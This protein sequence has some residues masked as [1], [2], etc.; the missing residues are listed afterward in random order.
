[1]S[2]KPLF[3]ATALIALFV[4]G[5]VFWYVQKQEVAVNQPVVTDSVGEAPAQVEPEKYPQHIE[6]IPGNTDEVWYNI[7][8]L[9]IRMKLNKEFAEDLIYRVNDMSGAYLS[10]KSLM[11]IDTHCT[12]GGLGLLF[13]AEGNM[14][15]TAETDDFL[16]ARTGD[17]I[18]VGGYYYGW[19]S[20][21]DS[22]WDP[23]NE[24]EIREI[25]PGQYDGSG[26][27]NIREGIKTIRLIS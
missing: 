27:K 21:H 12:P 14:R 4:I 24:K 26:A 15:E 25:F 22:C 9:G 23:K 18:Q 13:K 1:M 19:I 8:E 10:T 11:R 20:G 6:V 17:Y 5:G 3:L 16:A 7:P 2:H